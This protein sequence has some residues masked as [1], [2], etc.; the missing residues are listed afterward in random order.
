M[1]LQIQEKPTDVS[2]PQTSTTP[3]GFM[4][5]L[6]GMQAPRPSDHAALLENLNPEGKPLQ[7]VR[8][9]LINLHSEYH[10][11]KI[12]YMVDFVWVFRSFSF[13]FLDASIYY[14]LYDFCS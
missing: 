13:R 11:A 9:C 2:Q 7:D 12:D 1:Y 8:N 4:S 14:L 3:A 6:P 5:W 10:V